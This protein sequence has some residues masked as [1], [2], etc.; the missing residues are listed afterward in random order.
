[1]PN[2]TAAMNVTIQDSGSGSRATGGR[3]P[4]FAPAAPTSIGM[5]GSTFTQFDM[6]DAL[7][8][9]QD[10]LDLSALNLDGSGAKDF[11]GLYGFIVLRYISGTGSVAV[12][13]G[14]TNGASWFQNGTLGGASTQTPVIFQ[15]MTTGA[16]VT[17]SL[18]TIDL[19]VTGTITYS[20]RIYGGTSTTGG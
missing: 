15:P 8:S 13:P 9:T 19:T 7:T 5:F 11:T 1:M 17:G 10:D 4:W 12:G 2:V 16:L 20:M 18:K 14:T 3:D 6:N